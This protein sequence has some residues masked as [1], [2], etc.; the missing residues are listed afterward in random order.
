[1]PLSGAAGGCCS[2]RASP[3]RGLVQSMSTLALSR[4]AFDDAQARSPRAGKPSVSIELPAGGGLL[5]GRSE[6]WLGAAGL[7]IDTSSPRVGSPRRCPR[8]ASPRDLFTAVSQATSGPPGAERRCKSPTFHVSEAWMDH[9]PLHSGVRYERDLSFQV[10]EGGGSPRLRRSQSG[11]ILENLSRFESMAAGMG[12]AERS[13]R[14]RKMGFVKDGDNTKRRLRQDEMQLDNQRSQRRHDF[15]LR[16]QADSVASLGE[17]AALS[18]A[19][20]GTLLRQASS[21]DCRRPMHR[22]SPDVAAS[23]M[24][25][26][27]P[28]TPAKYIVGTR[29]VGWQNHGRRAAVACGPQAGMPQAGVPVL[30]ANA[31]DHRNSDMVRDLWHGGPTSVCHVAVPVVY[32]ASPVISPASVVH[33]LGSS[34]LPSTMPKDSAYTHAGLT[35]IQ[36]CPRKAGAFSPNVKR[37]PASQV[38]SL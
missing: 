10:G 36:H 24:P 3:R 28:Q 21:P 37:T 26:A 16:P 35:V 2:P 38:L 4:P 18:A 34:S 32:A 33:S 5:R 6:S 23:L 25:E 31:R 19:S 7:S 9:S 20:P 8:D 12:P 27:T 13:P 1:M 29:V 30:A 15:P 17:L 22:T 14:G 11:S